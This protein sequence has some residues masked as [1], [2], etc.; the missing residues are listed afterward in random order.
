MQIARDHV[1]VNKDGKRLDQHIWQLPP[2]IH[3][4]HVRRLGGMDLIY[5]R[6]AATIILG[7]CKSSHSQLHHGPVAGDLLSTFE[8]V[9]RHTRVCQS[10]CRSKAC[11]F[12]HV[13]Q[14]FRC[15]H[16]GGSEPCAFSPAVHFDDFTV[17]QYVMGTGQAISETLGDFETQWLTL[18]ELRMH[19]PSSAELEELESDW[20]SSIRRRREKVEE[21]NKRPIHTVA[22]P[23]IPRS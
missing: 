9:F 13:G 17:H 1:A 15:E 3:E 22:S 20:L 10:D 19:R 8:W 18:S 12:G 2:E 7:S 4:E 16:R 6:C 23:S 21:L 5:Q 11:F 14:K